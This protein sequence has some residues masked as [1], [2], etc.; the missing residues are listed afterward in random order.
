MT[1]EKKKGNSPKE[2]IAY[3]G[4]E[5][6]PVQISEFRDFWQSL[7]EEEKEELRTAELT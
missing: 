2:L 1:E 6:R 7:N 5:E 3:F 4:T